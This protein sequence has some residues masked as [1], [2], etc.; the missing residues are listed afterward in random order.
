[1]GIGGGAEGEGEC[2]AGSLWSTEPD[3]GLDLTT[4]RSQP[5]W[6]PRVGHLTD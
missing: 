2:E 6:K 3:A 1:M 4:L 5:E